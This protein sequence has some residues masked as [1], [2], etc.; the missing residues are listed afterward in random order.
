MKRIHLF[1]FEDLDWFPTLLRD[2]GT[3]FLQFLTI[4]TKMYSPIIPQLTKAL[5]KNDNNQMVDLGSG[6][7]GGL[8]GLVEELKIYNPK[9]KILLTDYYPNIDAFEKTKRKSENFDFI[10]KPI[11]ARDVP[12]ELKGVRTMFSSFHH[13]KPEDARKI[14]QNAVD[15][16][17]DI[18][19]F[20]GAERSIGNLIKLL[21]APLLVLFATPF[22]KPFKISRLFFTYIIPIIPLFVWWDGTISTL[23][24]Y[25][26]KEMND[27]VN[28]LD[29]KG[30]F[31]WE[32]GRISSKTGMNLYLIGTRKKL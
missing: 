27:L 28:Q 2:F 5:K 29:N 12:T 8:L 20:E 21:F 17:S 23:R 1:E 22:I 6:G 19:I 13:F 24:I 31:D 14:L 18:A 9:I 32:I 3:D 16:K 7:G 26:V 4:K 15:S 10:K 25:S 11:D 30:S